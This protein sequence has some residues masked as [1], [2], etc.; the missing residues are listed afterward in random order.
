M[1]DIRYDHDLL[2]DDLAEAKQAEKQKT[3]SEESKAS[4]L[5][6]EGDAGGLLTTGLEGQLMVPSSVKKVMAGVRRVESKDGRLV[7]TKRG[8]PPLGAKPEKGAPVAGMKSTVTLVENSVAKTTT[9]TTTPLRSPSR[10]SRS[11]SR[12]RRSTASR[13]SRNSS[14]RR[15]ASRKSRRHSPTGSVSSR[16]SRSASRSFSRS[17]SRSR[18]SRRSRS[19]SRSSDMPPTKRQKKTP[20]DS[21]HKSRSTTKRKKRS[22]RSYSRSRSCSRSR[23]SSSRATYDSDDNNNKSDRKA[24]ASDRP[25]FLCDVC[26]E[27]PFDSPKDVAEHEVEVHG[28]LQADFPCCWCRFRAPTTDQVTDHMK[29]IHPYRDFPLRCGWCQEVLAEKVNSSDDPAW[30]DLRR[31]LEKVRI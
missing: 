24:A 18:S 3:T 16:S 27:G 7:I 8:L 29:S 30:S 14:V 21:G 13:S 1:N 23:S 26:H 5:G 2:L 17:R 11:R 15:S 9:T 10:S 6:S 22:R 31:H 20:S 28:N 25:R 12:S 4:R 19:S